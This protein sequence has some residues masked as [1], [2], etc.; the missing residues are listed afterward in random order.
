MTRK[1]FLTGLAAGL[2]LSLTVATAQ[3]GP[4][5]EK[6]MKAGE[7]TVATDANWAPQSFINDKNE[8]DGFDVDVAKG[9]AE[10]MGVKIKFVTPAWDIITA[11]NWVGRWDM[12]VGSM[13]PTKKRGEIFTFPGIYYYT[14]AAVAV[15]ND[16][17]ATSMKDLDGKVVAATTTSTYELYLKKDLTIDAEGVPAFEYQIN[18]GTL[19]SLDNVNTAL[20]DLRLGDGVR[21]DAVVGSLPSFMEAKKNGYPIKILGD[22]VFYEPLSVAIENGDDELAKKISEAVEAMKADGTLSKLSVKW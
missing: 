13:T 3:A 6:V 14:P 17:K 11:G 5:L 21:L 7:I 22:P 18:P 15:H 4:V 16:S 8:L 20:D 19:R 12:H 1:N 9:I 10:R 2:A